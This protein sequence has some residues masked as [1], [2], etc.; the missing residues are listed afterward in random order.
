MDI[1]KNYQFTVFDVETTGLNPLAGDKITEIAAIKIV[2]GQISSEH[3]PFVSLVNPERIISTEAMQVSHITNEMVKSAPVI[4]DIIE[5]FL[6]FI[7]G[8]I[9]IAHN[10]EFDMSFLQRALQ[11]SNIQQPLPSYLCTMNISKK[12]FSY[13]VQHNLD[14]LMQR[15]RV[16]A[17]GDRHRALTDVQATAEV[18]IKLCERCPEII[19]EEMQATRS[20]K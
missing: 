16:K 9:L 15:M 7:S 11:L 19:T 12:I 4:G 18:F 10:A 14:I 5:P 3:E 8:T 1:L 6:S 20:R 17:E 13:Q 2:N